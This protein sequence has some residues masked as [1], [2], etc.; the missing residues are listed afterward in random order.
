[1][2]GFE[3]NSRIC[4]LG[5]SITHNNGY[6]S[7]IVGYYRQHLPERAV[8]FYNCGVSGGNIGTLFSNFE[9][10]IMSH[11][12]T[13]AVIMIGIN[14]S[15]REALTEFAKNE[16]RDFCRSGTAGKRAWHSPGLHDRE[17]HPGTGCRL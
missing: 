17:D 12:P 4:F 3:K 14:D 13:H 9:A 8:K 2:T 1:M 15:N 10:D 6:V 16:R 7:H 11:N 5:D